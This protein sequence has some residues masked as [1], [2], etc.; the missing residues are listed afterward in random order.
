MFASSSPSGNSFIA[1]LS[2]PPSATTAPANPSADHDDPTDPE[3]DNSPNPNE[4]SDCPGCLATSQ[5]GAGGNRTPVHQALSARATT[6]PDFVPAQG[7][8][9]VGRPSPE[10]GGPRIVFPIRHRS[11]PTPTV[12]PVAIPR[13][14]C[15]AA[16]DRPRAPLLVTMSLH[17]PEDQAARANCSLAILCGAPFSESEQ[18]GSH[19]QASG[20]DVETSQPLEL[21]L[22][23]TSGSVLPTSGGW[24]GGDPPQVEHPGACQDGHHHGAA[25]RHPRRDPSEGPDG[26]P[27]VARE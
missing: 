12:F 3:N 18:L 20:P 1:A 24:V 16:V 11:S 4:G 6:I 19:S 15:R 26:C 21:P 22:Q 2:N 27:G 14:C 13:F 7:H 10:G 5:R 9:R 25:D 8:R 23:A 17:S